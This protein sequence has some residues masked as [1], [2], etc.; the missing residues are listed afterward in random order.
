M[1]DFIR[2]HQRLMQGLLLLI[3]FPSFAFFGLEGYTRMS[4][5]DSAVAKIAGKYVTQEEVDAAHREQLDR[6]RNMFGQQFDMKMFDTPE[7]RARALE[8]LLSKRALIEEAARSNVR[9]SDATLQQA[10]LEEPA[11][12]RLVGPDGKFDSEQYRAML[13]NMGLS[14]AGFEQQ[15]RQDMAMRQLNGSIQNT[16]FAPKAVTDRLSEINEQEREVQELAF[17]AANF[18][19]QVKLTDQMLK[20]YYEKKGK[21]FEVP[22]QTRIEYVVLDQNAVAALIPVSDADVR[23]VYDQ[24]EQ[25]RASHILLEVK[26]D[27]SAADKA[28]VKAKA[29]GLLAQ[30]RKNPGDFAKLAKEHSQDTESGA[31]GGDLNFFARGVNGKEFDDAVFQLKQGEISNVVETPFGYHIIQVTAINAGEG[32]TFEQSKDALIAEIR[33]Q[34]LSRKFTETAEAFSNLVFNE[35]P[36]SLKPA[37]DKFKLKIETATLS[38]REPNPGLPPTVAYNNPKFLK[39]LFTDEAIKNKR[40]TEAVETAPGTMIAGR[41]VEYK[42]ASKKPFDEVKPALEQLVRQDEAVA[43]A[44]KAGEAKL[45]ELTAKPDA[46]GFGAARM[47]ARTKNADLP[48]PAF[49]AVMKADVSK[50]PTFVGVELPG[51]GYSLF[52]INKVGKPATSDAARR[53][54]EQQQVGRAQA[55]AEAM[56][57]IEALKKKADVEILKP[58]AGKEDAAS[59]QK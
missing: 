43:L 1:F 37:A 40:N 48:A 59:E 51:T 20:D 19:S 46:A 50:L 30:L 54:N 15:V 22:E 32:K 2:N 14:P 41:I 42:P 49:S 8:T 35:Q 56:A 24:K 53:N 31:R 57:Y 26:K 47:V 3:I 11:I 6:L 28:A 9:I 18:L 10:I 25:R 16:S 33:K 58:V 36:D 23:A 39:V 55:E 52:R 34:Q 38:G 45:A 13:A 12:R 17:S 29:E 7:A 44:K 27:A 21:I 4:A 5:G